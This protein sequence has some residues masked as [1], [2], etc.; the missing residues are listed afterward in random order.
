MRS[1]MW[2]GGRVRSTPFCMYWLENIG[3]SETDSLRFP[4]ED[5]W[6]GVIVNLETIVSREGI[7]LLISLGWTFNFKW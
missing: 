2:R 7:L 1:S 5:L 6:A 4:S 3:R